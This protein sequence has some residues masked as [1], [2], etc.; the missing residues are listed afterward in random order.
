MT[1]WEEDT[2]KDTFINNRLVDKGVIELKGDII[3]T[4][5]LCKL[6]R[7]SIWNKATNKHTN[8]V[9]I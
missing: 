3:L 8:D 9:K 1:L 5:F 7:T 6:T 2:L 4:V